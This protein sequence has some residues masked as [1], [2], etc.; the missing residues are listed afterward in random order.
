ML[1]EE[2]PAMFRSCTQKYS[3]KE[4]ELGT[5]VTCA[6]DML[7]VMQVLQS[8]ELKVKLPMLLEMDKK[9]A[10]DLAIIWSVSEQTTL[11][12][13]LIFMN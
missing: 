3:V 9:V 2:C 4:A 12:L 7:Y 8:L 1:L 10:V 11:I 6:Q 13:S 5:G